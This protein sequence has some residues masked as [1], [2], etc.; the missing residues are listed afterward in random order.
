MYLRK[1]SKGELVR[2]V[3]SKLLE[4][5]FKPGSID[6][7]Y[8]HKTSKAV[9]RFQESKSLE[10]DGITGPITFKALGI[11][12]KPVTP[13][14]ERKHFRKLLIGNP[15]YFG[16]L[17]AS[18]FEMVKPKKFDTSYEEL[19]CV[20]YD[21]QVKQLHAVV[22]IK[23]DYG[24]LG[25]LCSDGSL[26]Y[27]R[28][29]MDW[30]NDGNWVDL[31]MAHFTA[32]DLPGDKPLE[33]SVTLDIEPEEKNCSFEQLPK[34]RAIL[35]WND[36]PPPGDPTY[37]AVWGNVLD[38]RI[39]I[40]DLI[41]LKIPDFFHIGEITKSK[42]L[43][44]KVNL[45]Q[46]ISLSKT[47]ALSVSDLA[48]LYKDKGVP[49][50]RFAFSKLMKM[51]NKPTV[52]SMENL[53]LAEALDPVDV[54]PEEV[55]EAFFATDGDTRY[56]ELKCIGYDPQRRHL[57]GVLTVK[58]QSGYSGDLC[59]EGSNEY[60][61]F[62]EWDEIEAVWLYLGTAVVNVHDLNGIPNEGLQYAV[63]LGEDFIHRRRPC[64]VGPSE[65][66]IRAILSWQV[67]PP[68]HDPNWVPKWGN[69]EETRIHIKPGPKPTTGIHVPY[70]D[71]VG[72][73]HACDIKQDTGLATGDGM[74]A[75]F[76]ADR[77][78][79]ARTI[80]ITGSIDYPPTG[81]VEGI[82]PPLQY[83]VFVRPYNPVSPH[84]WQ[85][86]TNS[87]NVWVKE[88]DGV[89]LWV[90]K[91]ILQ[92]PD[93]EGFYT[94]LQD[95]GGVKRREY[96]LPILAS[97]PTNISMSG[98]WEIRIEARKFGDPVLI[99][100]G[101]FICEAD[102]S[103]RSIIKVHLDNKKPEVSIYL[104]GYQRGGDPT[105]HPIG[106]GT[107]EKCGKFL[108]GDVMHGSYSVSDDYFGRLTLTVLPSGPA[109]GASVAPP[110]RSFDI[111]PTTGES[112]TWSLDTSGMDPCGYIVRLWA[113]DRSIVD[114]GSIGLRKTDDAGFC[115]EEPVGEE[116]T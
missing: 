86:L 109:N 99:P 69:R 82:E 39:Q 26:E 41:E 28:F 67:P 90:H 70:I 47:K 40:D 24:F 31:G 113:R 104:T 51:L 45:N 93:I 9:V 21:P 95:P 52:A 4:L 18:K 59:D 105:I 22:H 74:I 85:Q 66:R 14:I 107:P 7:N 73:M 1:G 83:R 106:S 32:Y 72:N 78:P 58:L 103:T 101:T 23:R 49:A 15:N 27:V 108:K 10:T 43:L 16:T 3:Q 71:T 76:Q 34:V 96:V 81:V 77:S 17:N 25:N 38:A 79:F 60:V 44:K 20:G 97:W 68:P 50:H 46:S 84:T 5:G 92:E 100:G 116:D 94:Y 13:E 48:L 102:S 53:E 62:W 11:K 37:P 36:P 88:K 55:I 115:L 56:E 112:G 63:S 35:S 80:R 2:E 75:H 54:S 8:G 91:K 64:S 61:A 6:G 87:F 65:A 57:S 19:T 110:S 42:D 111:V 98:R 29:F 89:S 33:Y 30:D 114:S 12:V